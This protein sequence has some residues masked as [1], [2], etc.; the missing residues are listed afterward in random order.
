MARL[1]V[2]LIYKMVEEMQEHFFVSAVGKTLSML[3]K[4][5]FNYVWNVAFVCSAH[6]HQQNKNI[7]PEKADM[8]QIG[9]SKC[10]ILGRMVYSCSVCTLT[11]RSFDHVNPS[12]NHKDLLWIDSI[13]HTTNAALQILPRIT[14]L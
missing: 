2:L 5:K 8:Y 9:Q 3:H 12:I 10:C 11:T 1:Q 6:M 13:I 14:N 7:I 4:L